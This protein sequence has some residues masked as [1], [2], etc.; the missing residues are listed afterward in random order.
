MKPL[1]K[2]QDKKLIMTNSS[3]NIFQQELIF[4][5]SKAL[6][7]LN[8]VKR[9]CHN[10][11]PLLLH[12]RPSVQLSGGT[13]GSQHWGCSNT[14]VQEVLSWGL[15]LPAWRPSQ[16]GW[17]VPPWLTATIEPLCEMRLPHDWHMKPL[18]RRHRISRC[19]RRDDELIVDK[20][21]SWRK[22]PTNLT[23]SHDIT[24][25][26]YCVFNLWDFLMWPD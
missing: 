24:L 25:E 2:F 16:G 3:P 20:F 18:T 26:I 19:T 14:T 5:N 6:A 1:F 7:P 9:S 10:I 17:P 15:Q 21:S 8:K 22:P 23:W 13:V 11:V 12:T 4:Q